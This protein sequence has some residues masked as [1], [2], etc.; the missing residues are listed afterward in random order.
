MLLGKSGLRRVRNCMGELALCFEMVASSYVHQPNNSYSHFMFSLHSDLT[1]VTG[2]AACRCAA[3][4]LHGQS[5]P[6][7]GI[8]YG[9]THRLVATQFS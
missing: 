5:Y 8:P 1:R 4:C 3:L 9:I 2:V 6:T 7:K